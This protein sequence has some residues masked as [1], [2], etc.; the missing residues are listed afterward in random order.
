MVSTP[1]RRS[2]GSARDAAEAAFK[3]ATSKPVAIADNSPAKPPSLPQAKEQ[4]SIRL[5]REVL[6]RFQ[7]DGPG[8]QDRINAAL[9]KALGL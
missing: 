3:S 4:V 5:D 1:A 6:E 8:W 2:F 9:R 7:E